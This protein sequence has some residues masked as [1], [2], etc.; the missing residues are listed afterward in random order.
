[1]L[2]L[3]DPSLPP[4][5][6]QLRAGELCSLAPRQPVWVEC[7]QGTL[8]VTAGNED[9][10]LEANQGG[11]FEGAHNVVVQALGDAVVTLR[12]APPPSRRQR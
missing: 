8:W 10:V 7:L 3:P 4:E 12:A 6:R 1:M 11:R 9:V 5:T 2:L